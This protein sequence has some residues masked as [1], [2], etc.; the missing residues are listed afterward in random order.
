MGID[1]QALSKCIEDKKRLIF[2]TKIPE[3]YLSD[4]LGRRKGTA[5]ALVFP[6]TTQEVSS[7]L[8]YAHEN[9]VPVTP[10]GAGTNLVGS[11]VPLKGGILLDLSSMNRVLE[12]DEDYVAEIVDL[13]KQNP[14]KTDV[15]IAGEYLRAHGGY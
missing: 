3:E 4:A 12:L 9:R 7:V 5:D 1:K 11:T 10:R 8:R 15:E 6:L 14:E 13:L 2:D